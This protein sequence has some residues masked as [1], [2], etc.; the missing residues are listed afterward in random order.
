MALKPGSSLPLSF[1]LQG[2]RR[3]CTNRLKGKLQLGSFSPSVNC[4]IAEDGPRFPEKSANSAKFAEQERIR[5]S[6][7]DWST[8]M[9]DVSILLC[10][11]SQAVL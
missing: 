2:A 10:H 3:L 5:Q 6:F 4:T 7:C 11:S 9:S 8:I 1:A